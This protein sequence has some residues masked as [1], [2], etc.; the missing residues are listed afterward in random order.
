MNSYPINLLLEKRKCLIAGGGKVAAR[1]LEQLLHAGADIKV[2]GKKISDKIKK[3]AESNAFELRE[4][5]FKESDLDNIFL[6][7]I[8][9]DDRR[10][11]LDI[12]KKAEERGILSCLVDRNWRNGSFITPANIKHKEV[13]V[14]VSTQGINCRKSRLIKEN[15]ARGILTLSKNRNC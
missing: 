15:L 1:K 3:S 8:A 14:A 6:I 2:I 5:S 4:R 12:L 9:T 7:Y 11:N 13:S 10:L